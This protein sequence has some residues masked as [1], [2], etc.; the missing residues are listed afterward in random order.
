MVAGTWFIWCSIKLF[1]WNL[2]FLFPASMTMRPSPYEFGDPQGQN[3]SMMPWEQ[4]LTDTFGSGVVAF[5]IVVARLPCVRMSKHASTQT[6]GHGFW[7]TQIFGSRLPALPL[8]VQRRANSMVTCPLAI[9]SHSSLPCLAA[10]AT[11][12]RARWVPQG[13]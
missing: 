9:S 6:P 2:L 11:G 12:R 1:M 5:A 13:P 10:C 7:H 8:K 3:R 4:Y